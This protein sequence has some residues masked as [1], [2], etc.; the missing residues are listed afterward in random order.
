[1]GRSS[2]HSD[3]IASGLL[4]DAGVEGLYH[5]S[6]LFESV[7]RGLQDYVTRAAQTLEDHILYF[8]PIMARSTLTRTGYVGSFPN[9]TGSISSFVGNDRD[10]SVLMTAL[11]ADEEWSE[12]FTPTDVVT[13]SAVCHSL[14]P[15]LAGTV[16]P[17]GGVVYELQGTCF[18][19]EPSDDVG[20]MQSFRMHEIV[21]VGGADDALQHRESWL[22]RGFAMLIN[23]GLGVEI[24]EANDPFFGRAGLLLAS[25]QRE[26]K[27]KFEIVAEIGSQ[28][29]GAV[30]SGNLHE[31]HFGSRFNISQHDGEVAQSACFG[32]G[33]ERITLALFK[34]HGI[35][36]GDWPVEV[37]NTLDLRGR[38]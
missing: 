12:F 13:C 27:L 33:L 11:N 35:S 23:L 34:E 36:V 4:I 38:I 30:S 37:L 32:F 24:S 21:F 5:R 29:P 6:F 1:M 18:R 28:S 9:L 25:G 22:E 14:Y 17:G 16:L 15:L 7:V 8:P 31:G 26:K 2:F 19:H 3:V 20:R 10:L